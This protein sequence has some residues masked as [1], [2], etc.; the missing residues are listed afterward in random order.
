MKKILI[1]L[2]IT[3]FA[4]SIDFIVGFGYGALEAKTEKDSTTFKSTNARDIH[5]KAGLGF[6]KSRILVTIN[7][8]ELNGNEELT[9]QTLSWQAVDQ[10]DPYIKG[11]FGLAV[12]KFD[13]TNTPLAIKESK[14]V[15]G[16]ELGI[17]LLEQG[18]WFYEHSEMEFGYRY[19]TTK[20]L[21]QE[22]E[23]F[24]LNSFSNYYV[25]LN[26]KF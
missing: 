8:P 9:V 13:Y 19:F 3:S 1:F 10:P 21:S 7:N 24:K 17:M 11:F 18:N 2:L 23:N 20:G 26:L 5:Y 14:D 4:F 25:G 16:L 6:E 12:G 15:Y 22:E